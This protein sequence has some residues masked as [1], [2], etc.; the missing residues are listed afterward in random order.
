MKKFFLSV[1][2]LLSIITGAFG[3]SGSIVGTI[4]DAGD[5]NPLDFV[6]IAL[7]KKGS[8][9]P[10][11]LAV[12]DNNGGFTI[13]SVENGNYFLRITYVG[14]ASIIK[15]VE[16]TG[17]QL[18]LGI[19]P[20]T[21][22]SK[23]LKG[24]EVV[25]QGSQMKF[26]IDKKVFS[27]DQNL[28]AAGGSASEV[29]QNIPS[30][31]VD[32]EGNVSLRNSPDVEVWINGKPA[33]LTSD[34]R[35]QILQQM[36][37]ESIESVEIMTNP[38]A[39]FK[40]EGSSGIINLVM[41]KNRKAGYYGSVSAGGMYN[42]DNANLGGTLGGSFN[43]SSDKLEA[44]VNIGYRR[45][46]M[47]SG[48]WNSRDTYLNNADT[49]NLYQTNNNLRSRG[50]LFTRLSLDYHLNKNNTIS[51]SAFGMM[52]G[53]SSTSTID[54]LLTDKATNTVL[55]NYQRF[56]SG[57]GTRDHLHSNLD[58]KHDFDKKGSNITLSLG[59][60]HYQMAQ[61]QRYTQYDN[62]KNKAISSDL[63]QTGSGNSSDYEFKIDYT[64]KITE[65]SKLEAGWESD[66]TRQLS[67]ASGYDFKTGMNINSYY[68]NFDYTEQNHAGYLTYGNKF[69]KFNFQAGLRAEYFSKSYINTGYSNQDKQ[70]PEGY[71]QLYPSLF[72]SYSLPQNNEIQ[73]N[74]TRRVNRPNGMQLNPYKNYSDSSNVT[75]GNPALTP[76]YASAYELNYIKSWDA[77]TLSACAY[78]RFT[79]NVIQGVSFLQNAV[80]QSTSVNLTKQQNSGIEIVAKDRIFQ[81]VNLTSSLNLYYSKIDSARYVK[82]NV[83]LATIPQQELFTWNARV[84][85]NF[86]LSKTFF[87]QITAEY[88]APH[89]I[90]QGKELSNFAIDLGL[91]KTLLDR[92]LNLNL[93]VRDL[94]D[95]RNRKTITSGAGYIQTNYSNWGGRMIGLT[96]TYNF[97]NMKPKPV[98]MKKM[99]NS[100]G[101]MMG[102]ED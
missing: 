47:P 45:M 90:A 25:G 49:L 43:Y 64:K 40:P 73:L 21:E 81:V 76:E 52:G 50:G 36:P 12:T 35:G 77:H 62:L 29:L 39:K 78:Y 13:P 99:Q 87:G 42:T 98:D 91:R 69:D 23:E 44:N 6:N 54:N 3:A 10:I 75:Y 92:K 88:N 95:S 63:S 31:S 66:Y 58:F 51:L 82:D 96:A 53:G 18:A 67:G 68:D 89:L 9:K 20:L 4:V 83:V 102:G 100:G 34:N 30:V 2:L 48:G 32:N 60:S 41:K 14:Y 94:F 19:I 71:F 101:D 1:V 97:G 57:D 61:T 7:L 93:M 15:P 55:K 46:N 70:D 24:V 84:M 27:V 37:A 28:A 85:A 5:R 26:E 80:M 56:S 11:T 22:D 79:D 16:V 38:S 72:L 65:N 33:G 74:Y 8:P 86:A 59:Y 17:K